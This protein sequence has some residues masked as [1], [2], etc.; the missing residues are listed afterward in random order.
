MTL[1]LVAKIYHPDL[2]L[3]KIKK[4][5]ETPVDTL[6]RIHGLRTTIPK[7]T[8]LWSYAIIVGIFPTTDSEITEKFLIKPFPDLEFVPA[9]NLIDR[10]IEHTSVIN[11]ADYVSQTKIHSRIFEPGIRQKVE[12]LNLL[13][14]FTT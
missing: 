10:F 9:F 6:M 8:S 2:I 11:F 4:E 5:D 12:D 3:K 7:Y 14:Y 13:P 1:E